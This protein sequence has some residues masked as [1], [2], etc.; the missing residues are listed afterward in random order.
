MS[1]KRTD[2]TCHLLPLTDYTA[3]PVPISE[4]AWNYEFYRQLVGLHGQGISPSQGQHKHRKNVDIQPS[5][6]DLLCT[7][8]IG[9]LRWCKY[10]G[11]W[12]RSSSNIV[13][14]FSM[15]VNIAEAWSFHSWMPEWAPFQPRR[16]RFESHFR[17]FLYFLNQNSDAWFGWDSNP[18][19]QCSSGR[20]YFMP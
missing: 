9:I 1:M 20:R 19:P 13:F 16:F 18:Q 5:R 7:T 17:F 2:C 11:V 3:W 10:C 12:N 15:T 6:G 14:L 4:L 8:S